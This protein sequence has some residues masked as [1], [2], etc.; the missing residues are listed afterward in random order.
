[1]G[2][3]RL[4]VLHELTTFCENDRLAGKSDEPERCADVPETEESQSFS[5]YKLNVMKTSTEGEMEAT[6]VDQV[7]EHRGKCVHGNAGSVPSRST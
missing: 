5:A 1:M 3:K 4:E 6:F 2:P 7:T